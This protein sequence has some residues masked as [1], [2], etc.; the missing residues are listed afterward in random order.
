MTSVLVSYISFS[1]AEAM[2]SIDVEETKGET[3]HLICK[4]KVDSWFATNN[5]GNK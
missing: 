1:Y 2:V 4:V 3:I 5:T